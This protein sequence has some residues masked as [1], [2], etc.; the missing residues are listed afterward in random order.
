MVHTRYRVAIVESDELVRQLIVR[1]LGDAGHQVVERSVSPGEADLVIVDVSG[2]RHATAR[3]RA[4]QAACASRILVV[5]ASFRRDPGQPDLARQLSV[6]A[7]LP[8]PF[9]GEALHAAIA[10]AMRED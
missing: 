9:T 8:K 1:W 6:H 10:Q 2:R 3:I 5:S 7:V 4:I